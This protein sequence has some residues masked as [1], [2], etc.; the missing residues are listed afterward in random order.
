MLSTCGSPGRPAHPGRCPGLRMRG[1]QG[2][3]A[4]TQGPSSAGGDWQA[5]PA[6][7]SGP[8]EPGPRIRTRR[9]SPGK[10][11]ARG[12]EGPGHLPDTRIVSRGQCGRP[13]RLIAP[14]WNQ[15]ARILQ[16]GRL[17]VSQPGLGPV[18]EM[19]RAWASPGVSAAPGATP[20]PT[21]HLDV[22]LCRRAPSPSSRRCHGPVPATAA[23]P[24]L[25]PLWGAGDQPPPCF[26]CSQEGFPQRDPQGNPQH[27]SHG[28]QGP[29]ETPCP[30]WSWGP[31]LTTLPA[32]LGE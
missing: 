31:P 13:A 32:E 6:D 3:V 1:L 26:R 15:T 27:H 16:A 23:H 30:P 10:R 29:S 28:V 8:G 17:G 24:C 4:A 11:E 2:R 25:G 9:Q 5:M 20:L 19:R 22:H 12:A 7:W 18:G 14:S 21:L